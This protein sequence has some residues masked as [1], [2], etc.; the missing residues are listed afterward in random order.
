MLDSLSPT[1]R[2]YAR[3]AAL[4]TAVILPAILVPLHVA[5][6]GFEAYLSLFPAVALG[7]LW[8]VAGNAIAMERFG[9]RRDQ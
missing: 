6:A 9:S 7:V 2:L 4:G 1:E 3:L 8:G 5:G